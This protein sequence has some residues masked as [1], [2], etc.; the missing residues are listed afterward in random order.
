MATKKITHFRLLH[1]DKFRAHVAK[2]R[3]DES[4][5]GF[6]RVLGVS[7]QYLQSVET[8]RRP[9]SEAFAAKFPYGDFVCRPVT[10]FELIP[11]KV[12]NKLN[13]PAPAK[14]AKAKPEAKAKP[15][16]K[17]VAKDKRQLEM[18]IPMEPTPKKPVDANRNPRKR[19]PEQLAA[20]KAQVRELRAQEPPV[21]FGAISKTLGVPKA[22]V[23]GWSQQGAA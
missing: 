11:R 3:G 14:K 22:S 19:T 13:A 12:W 4:L 20:L 7:A 21:S 16:K 6:A 2:T 18:V 8:G 1:D 10:A 5:R 15:R 23:I 17:R 9:A